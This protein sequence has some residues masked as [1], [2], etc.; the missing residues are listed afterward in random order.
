[1]R[2][3]N[4]YP[5]AKPAGSDENLLEGTVLEGDVQSCQ[6]QEPV[7][8]LLGVSRRTG[9]CHAPVVG[10]TQECLSDQQTPH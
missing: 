7:N 3:S 5:W 1:V 4:C 10:S 9:R 8:C 6:E 2:F